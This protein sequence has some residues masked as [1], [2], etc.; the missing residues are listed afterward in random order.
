MNMRIDQLPLLMVNADSSTNA[1]ALS[2]KPV[3]SIPETKCL[4]PELVALAEKIDLN[5]ASYAKVAT[6]VCQA[7]MANLQSFSTDHLKKLE[8]RAYLLQKSGW[9]STIVQY[10]SYIGSAI[11]LF[12]G[13]SSENP[14]SSA[15]ALGLGLLP[16]VYEAL[17]CGVDE[18]HL[19]KRIFQFGVLAGIALF[20]ARF[21][22]QLPQLNSAFL[23]PA[24]SVIQSVIQSVTGIMKTFYDVRLTWKK[25]ELEALQFLTSAIQ[26]KLQEMTGSLSDNVKTVFSNTS[27]LNDIMS[28]YI[29][30]KKTFT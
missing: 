1:S 28:K 10:C 30:T 23:K 15:I 20:F 8:E 3:L 19:E 14:V 7:L 12:V 9:W 6:T 11:S 17:S 25:G 27:W 21:N 29:E 2:L 5:N 16:F 24:L 22:I 4:G 13:I 18:R 26:K